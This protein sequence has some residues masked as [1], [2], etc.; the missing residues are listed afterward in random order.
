MYNKLFMATTIIMLLTLSG[1]GKTQIVETDIKTQ[2][3]DSGYKSISVDRTQ[4]YS[5]N[6]SNIEM[7]NK[8]FSELLNKSDE[9]L[10]EDIRS[11]DEYYQKSEEV[12]EELDIEPYSYTADISFLIN[13]LKGANYLNGYTRDK[14]SD[15][16]LETLKENLGSNNDIG[17]SEPLYYIHNI[18]V[19]KDNKN[20]D[21]T[22]NSMDD[23]HEYPTMYMVYNGDGNFE[24]VYDD[25]NCTDKSNWISSLENQA[26]NFT[27][28]LLVLDY[29]KDNKIIKYEDQNS[30]IYTVYLDDNNKICN[31]IEGSN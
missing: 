12:K 28:G 26:E 2:N 9:E 14:I 1:C 30:I 22:I 23:N 21:E 24:F 4:N 7:S 5:A 16:Y 8:E 17:E 19:Y 10:L 31:I 27:L 11:N 15:E 25:I 18:L 13:P 29:D 6:T 20:F 3:V